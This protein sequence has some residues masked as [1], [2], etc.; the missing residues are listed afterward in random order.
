LPFVAAAVSFYGGQIA[1]SSVPTRPPMIELTPQIQA[2]LLLAFGGRDASI[3]GDDVAAIRTALE[4]HGKR[5]ELLVYPDEDHAFFR[6]G[7][8]A[9]DGARAVWP[10]VRTFL[11]EHLSS[12]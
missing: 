9:N 4:E 12:T 11:S 3:S 1:R 7:P 10:S 6:A 2:P 5:F 8:D